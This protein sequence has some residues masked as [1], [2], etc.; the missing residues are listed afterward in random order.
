M[1]SE[2]NET[3]PPGNYGGRWQ[4]LC[5]SWRGSFPRTDVWQY[6]VPVGESADERSLTDVTTRG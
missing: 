3:M 1:L 5:G 4:R 2:Y 6:C